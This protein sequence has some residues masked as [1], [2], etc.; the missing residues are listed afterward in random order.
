MLQINKMFK[1]NK[2]KIRIEVK[3]IIILTETTMEMFIE[4]YFLLNK[5]K[6][7]SLSKFDY[8]KLTKNKIVN[9]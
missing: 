2:N 5:A 9:N 8:D 4:N 6:I 3:K 1:I 7:D